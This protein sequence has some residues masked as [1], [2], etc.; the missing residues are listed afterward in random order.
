MRGLQPALKN[1][2][3]YGGELKI[4][5]ENPGEFSKERI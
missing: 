1:L 4:N 5:N 2:K 3:I